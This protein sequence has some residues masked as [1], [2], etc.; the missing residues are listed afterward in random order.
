MHR[1]P[2]SIAGPDDV[3]DARP[4]LAQRYRLRLKRRRLLWRSFRSRHDLVALADRSGAIRAGDI[5]AVMVVRNEA[6]RL[7]YMLD[8]YRRLGVS[9]FLVV[10]NMSSD[11]TVELLRAA[12]DVSLWQTGAS[13]RDARFGLDWAS[14]LLMHFGHDHWCL[15]ADADEL[16]VYAGCDHHDLRDLTARLEARGQLAFGALMLDL[17]AKG[18]VGEADAAPGTDPVQAIS[19]F[20]AG[21]YRAVR[22]VPGMNLWV[23]G[24]M[25]E[26]MFFA[27]APE[28]SPTLN[29]LPLLRWNRRWA[30]T[31]SSHALLPWQVNMA[32]SGPGGPEP[33]GVLLH[34][35]FLADVVDR[36]VED[37]QRRQH[38]HDPDLLVPYYRAIA[39]RPVLWTP[40][41]RQLEGWETLVQHGLMPA[42]DW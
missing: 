11:A 38:F 21:P 10:D 35:K 25:R 15:M 24:G 31:N 13:Y 20:D 26:R 12:P 37:L 23:Q 7:P 1:S 27:D 36:A 30:F 6:Q 3:T 14:W 19:W 42:I 5:L 41:S 29:K 34:T 8:H 32:W 17:Y 39:A 33:A 16:L 9:H 40:D 28:R 4:S 22:Q 2:F 18:P